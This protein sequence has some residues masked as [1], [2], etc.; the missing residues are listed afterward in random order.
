[1]YNSNQSKRRSGVVE[2]EEEEVPQPL[3]VRIS[4]IKKKDINEV[5]LI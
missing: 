1:M 5:S 4:P 3:N 2:T